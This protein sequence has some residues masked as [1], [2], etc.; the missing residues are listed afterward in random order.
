MS[1]ATM[2]DEVRQTFRSFFD[3]DDDGVIE[4]WDRRAVFRGDKPERELWTQRGREG[5]PPETY[6]LMVRLGEDPVYEMLW[7]PP[8]HV[9]FDHWPVVGLSRDG[10]V[11]VIALT[12]EDW[13][14]ALLYTG[15]QLAGGSEEDL[16]AAR[17]DAGREAVR[18]GDEMADELDRDLPDLEVLGERFER[19][20][21][22]WLDAWAEVAEELD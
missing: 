19:A 9:A 22:K 13:L 18:K 3:L 17:E 15:G 20:Q 16:E 6:T 7:R 12:F 4:A 1:V 8:G 2:L 14:D 11:T 5:T 10:D 21:D